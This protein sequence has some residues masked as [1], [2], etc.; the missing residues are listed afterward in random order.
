MSVH[1]RFHFPLFM[2]I[3]I[4][5]VTVFTKSKC[6]AVFIQQGETVT[7][8]QNEECFLCWNNKAVDLGT[9]ENQN[10]TDWVY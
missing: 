4:Y 3:S 6:V 7:L 8:H 1:L 10:N 9:W 2:Q 5:G